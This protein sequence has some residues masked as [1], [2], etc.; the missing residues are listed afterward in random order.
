MFDAKCVMHEIIAQSVVRTFFP[1][2]AP[3]Q[4]DLNKKQEVVVYDQ[5]S[6]DRSLL[7]KDSFLN[8]LLAKLEATFYQ[9][10]L[11]TGRTT[12]GLCISVS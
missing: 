10:S 2:N 11:L 3:V 9:V 1:F 5:S 12:L 7:P 8:I 4:L 6:R